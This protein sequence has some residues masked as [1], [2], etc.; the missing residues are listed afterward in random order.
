[1]NDERE[2]WKQ[3]DQHAAR[4]GFH[5]AGR[6]A[7]PPPAGDMFFN[8]PFRPAERDNLPEA[9]KWREAFP[10]AVETFGVRDF[11]VLYYAA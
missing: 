2:L 10:A 7:P 3:I 6:P 1:M 5:R 8:P 9:P 11:S 4:A